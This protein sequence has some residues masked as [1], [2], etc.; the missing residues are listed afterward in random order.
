MKYS[1]ET[2]PGNFS[3]RI[4]KLLGKHLKNKISESE[5][6][7]E[8]EEWFVISM[9]HEK[10]EC[11]QLELT[12]KLAINKVK[13]SRLATALENKNIIIRNSNTKD[14]RLR[15]LSLSPEGIELYKK[16]EP[17]AESVIQKAFKG[18]NKNEYIQMI[19]FCN[20]I[21]TNLEDAE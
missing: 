19:A 9:L 21:L 5:I 18:F 2:S 1:F 10:Q 20:R 4:S 17:L 14:K 8:T 3:Y 12:E 13:I 7:L 15:R 16:T 6:D 11:S